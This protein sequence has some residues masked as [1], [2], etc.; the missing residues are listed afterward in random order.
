MESVL[1]HDTSDLPF[2][3]DTL[4]DKL[5]DP[6]TK[7]KRML[8]EKQMA[9]LKLGREKRWKKLMEQGQLMP[10]KQPEPVTQY[11]S[12]TSVSTEGYDTYTDSSTDEELKKQKKLKKS[13]PRQIRRR[14]DRYIKRKLRES[15]RQPKTSTNDEIDYFSLPSRGLQYAA[16][17]TP[18]NTPY[19]YTPQPLPEK[20]AVPAGPVFM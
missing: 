11:T 6:Q 4:A 15:Q 19:S 1:T 14:V 8:S 13:I 17:S 3:S 10:E 20:P 7:K 2:P 9:A 18:Y 5:E 12:D 16:P